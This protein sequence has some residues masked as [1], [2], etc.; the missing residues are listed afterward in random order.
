MAERIEL[1]RAVNFHTHLAGGEEERQRLD[2]QKYVSQGLPAEV[3][4]FVAMVLDGKEGSTQVMRSSI[5]VCLELM[6][7]SPLSL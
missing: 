6:V 7:E 3:A 5:C 2:S 4:D 1:L